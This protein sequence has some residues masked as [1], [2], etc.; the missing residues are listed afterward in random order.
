MPKNF[1]LSELKYSLDKSYN[2]KIH[3]IND[4]LTISALEILELGKIIL[5]EFQERAKMPVV[6]LNSAKLAL[7]GKAQS[8]TPKK[9]GR[10][11]GSKNK[12]KK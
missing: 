10:P 11:K 5:T 12:A 4:M 9:R 2:L 8:K 7:T 3:L 1:K 6:A